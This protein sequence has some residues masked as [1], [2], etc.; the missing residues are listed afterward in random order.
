MGLEPP[1]ETSDSHRAFG[2]GSTGPTR[3][4]SPA[5][6]DMDW[7]A[8]LDRLRRE[9]WIPLRSWIF[10]VDSGRWLRHALP[11]RVG[12]LAVDGGT[13]SPWGYD[14]DPN[15]GEILDHLMDRVL[16]DPTLNSQRGSV[17]A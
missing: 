5:S 6:P 12:E 9:G 14:P 2:T 4:G 7:K 8:R 15:F 17:A 10:F 11:L 1:L 16:E 13:S 3:I